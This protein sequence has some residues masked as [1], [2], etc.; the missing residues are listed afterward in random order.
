MSLKQY[1]AILILYVYTQFGQKRKTYL[2]YQARFNKTFA[3]ED[4]VC[5]EKALT[6]SLTINPP[7]STRCKKLS[8]KSFK[9]KGYKTI[10]LS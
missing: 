6:I 8:D 1:T 5:Y 10:S 3:S 9:N 7:K 2:S 4:Y